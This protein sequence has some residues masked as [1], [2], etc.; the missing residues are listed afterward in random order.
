MATPKRKTSQSRKRMRRSHHALKPAKTTVC[1][2]CGER[3]LPHR[4]CPKC[5]YYKARKW[6]RPVISVDIE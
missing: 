2:N 4:A 5:G 1:L 6:H 3:M